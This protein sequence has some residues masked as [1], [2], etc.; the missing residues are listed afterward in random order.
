[1]FEDKRRTRRALEKTVNEI[2]SSDA[3]KAEAAKARE[4]IAQM[5]ASELLQMWILW[6][7]L[8][9]RKPYPCEVKT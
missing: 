6:L 3:I 1:M 9:P 8:Q 4:R 2:G 5:G 7:S